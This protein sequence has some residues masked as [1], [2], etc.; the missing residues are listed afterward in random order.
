MIKSKTQLYGQHFLKDENI[1]DKI[2]KESD[3]HFDDVVLEI[4]PGHQALT[5]DLIKCSEKFFGLEI[6]KEISRKL[7]RLYSSNKSVKILN[8]DARYFNPAS[9]DLKDMKYILV[10][11]LPYYSANFIVRKFLESSIRPKKLI[12]MVQKEVA[13][14]MSAEI[15]KMKLLSVTTQFFGDVIKLFDVFPNSFSPPPKV[16]S[17]VVKIKVRE[18]LS[19]NVDSIDNFF[20]FVK[21]GFKSPR[22]KI[23]NSLSLG[24]SVEKERIIE[25]LKDSNVNPDD[26]PSILSI[27][28]WITLYET[29]KKYF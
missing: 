29:N 24:L 6:D 11:N 26:R 3:I 2:I 23:H 28:D 14:S 21:A 9:L 7:Q 22:K 17:S 16:I 27:N 5:K 20:T 15:G 13:E 4:G 18:K 25:L 12:I 10:G 1:K 19:Y 8:E